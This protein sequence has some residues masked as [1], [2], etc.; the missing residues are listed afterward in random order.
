M[1]YNYRT[2]KEN[3]DYVNEEK[4]KLRAIFLAVPAVTTKMWKVAVKINEIRAVWIKYVPILKKNSRTK[5][6]AEFNR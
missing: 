2:L 3:D 6:G 4:A 5:P 1:F